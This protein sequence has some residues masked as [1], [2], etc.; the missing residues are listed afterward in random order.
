M[1]VVMNKNTLSLMIL[2]LLYCRLVLV[3]MA[4]TGD[5]ISK[6]VLLMLLP[7]AN[8]QQ[9]MLHQAMPLYDTN[10]RNAQLSKLVFNFACLLHV[11]SVVGSS[12]GRQLY[13]QYG[14]FYIH[15]CEQ[16]GGQDNVYE[17]PLSTRLL[18]YA[19]K[20]ILH[21]QLSP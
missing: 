12:S 14:T 1:W 11:V 20:T 3:V 9:T 4:L 7:D 8:W 21:I 13:I 16:S 2:S 15:W 6:T 18:T 19:Y 10:Q 17:T 5:K